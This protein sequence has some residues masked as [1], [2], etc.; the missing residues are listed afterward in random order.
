MGSS[1]SAVTQ[2]HIKLLRSF[3]RNALGKRL[4]GTRREK[5]WQQSI[6]IAGI[7]PVPFEVVYEEWRK[8]VRGESENTALVID[9][10]VDHRHVRVGVSYGGVVTASH[11]MPT[12]S[13]LRSLLAVYACGFKTP[14]DFYFDLLELCPKPPE[15][16]DND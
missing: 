11:T 6:A 1:K 2:A 10:D 3:G 4:K 5:L 9:A 16:R 15:E 13:A 7:A 12:K 8:L 14:E